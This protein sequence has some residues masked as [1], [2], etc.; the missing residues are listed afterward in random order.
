MPQEQEGERQ[1]EEVDSTRSSLAR[2]QVDGKGNH[3][4]RRDEQGRGSSRPI[5]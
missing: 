3:E 5:P 1:L 4:N 2:Q